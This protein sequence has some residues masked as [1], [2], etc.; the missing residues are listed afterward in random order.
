MGR[1]CPSSL[2]A[3]YKEVALI[4]ESWTPGGPRRRWLS[5]TGQTLVLQ[6]LVV[7]V[8]VAGAVGVTAWLSSQQL[9]GQIEQRALAVARTTAENGEIRDQVTQLGGMPALPANAELRSGTVQQLGEQIRHSTGALYVVITDRAGLRLSHPDPSLLGRSATGASDT[10]LAGG[11]STDIDHGSLGTSARARVPIWSVSST[12]R[13]VGEVSVG[14]PMTAVHQAM[15]QA[16]GPLL[17]AM[18]GALAISGAA[19]TLLARRLRSLT[20]ELEPEQ[21]AALLQDQEVVLHGVAEG[22][23]GVAP[24]GHVTVCTPKARRML[25]L[26]NV[27]G[28]QFRTLGLPTAVTRLITHPSDAGYDAQVI[29][30]GSVLRVLARPVIRGAS[31][32]GWVLTVFDR[33]QIVALTEQLDAVAALS[34]A[35]RVQRHEFANRLH[36]ATGLLDIGQPEDARQFLHQTLESGPVR[37]PLANADQLPDPYLK[38]FLGAK[39]FEASERGVQLRIGEETVIRGVVSDP[40]DIT[41]VL[42]NLVDNA[43]EAAVAGQAASRWV[44]IELMNDRDTLH[45]VVADSG[46][47]VADGPEPPFHEGYTTAQRSEAGHGQGL[48][49]PLSRRIARTLGGDLWLAQIG[50]PGGPGAVFCARLPGVIDRDEAPV[51]EREGESPLAPEGTV[52]Q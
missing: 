47:G 52:W 35:L 14:F 20:R 19:S 26:G 21:I 31:N 32:L 44:E 2:T 42:G 34:N 36:T 50:V 16:I 25:R 24:D 5:F 13:V 9:T 1:R 33:T 11:E 28:R 43:I 45:L 22:V 39:A 41:T 46:D 38:A 18:A 8:S 49:L 10:V 15:L 6:L 30:A 40:H 17:F 51:S 7:V 27:I 37:Y 29:I 12:R 4:D 23:L 3:G 48:G